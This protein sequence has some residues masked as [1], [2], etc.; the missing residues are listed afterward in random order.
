MRGRVEHDGSGLSFTAGSV[1]IT[2]LD[3]AIH[4]DDA[5]VHGD[6]EANGK[7]LAKDVRMLRLDLDPLKTPTIDGGGVVTLA[8]PR[9]RITSALATALN[10][11]F[12]V[13]S[14][15]SETLV[16]IMTSKLTGV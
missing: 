14:F 15:A 9:V 10:G 4:L 6:I 3:F 5:T 7:A 8:G 1:K 11:A 13:R 16:G 12:H 2:L